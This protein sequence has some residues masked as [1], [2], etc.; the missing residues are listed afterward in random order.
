LYPFDVRLGGTKSLSGRGGEE[1]NFQKRRE[2]NPRNWI[3]QPVAQGYTDCAITALNNNGVDNSKPQQT[4]LQ[5]Q[6]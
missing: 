6:E 3:V 4:N 5:F 2:S 1:K